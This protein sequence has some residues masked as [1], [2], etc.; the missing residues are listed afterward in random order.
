MSKSPRITEK[1]LATKIA[2]KRLSVMELSETLGL[3]TS[4]IEEPRCVLLKL[5]VLLRDLIGRFLMS[6]LRWFLEKTSMKQ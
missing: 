2:R 6:F 1:D 3:T 5:M 4:S